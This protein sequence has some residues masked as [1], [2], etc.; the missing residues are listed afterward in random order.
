MAPSSARSS[1]AALGALHRRVLYVAGA[2]AAG[3]LLVLPLLY[4]APGAAGPRGLLPTLIAVYLARKGMQAYRT[5]RRVQQL[6]LEARFLAQ[7]FE[8]GPFRDALT[9]RG[10]LWDSSFTLHGLQCARRQPMPRLLSGEEKKRRVRRCCAR[11][12][13][14]LRPGRLAAF[15]VLPA[16]VLLV[17]LAGAAG[18]LDGGP[19]TLQLG[20]LALPHLLLVEAALL[21][22]RRR[23]RCAHD[24]LLDALTA[25]ALSDDV[26]TAFCERSAYNH[27]LLYHA[28]PHFGAV[29]DVKRNA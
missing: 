8:A 19:L 3:A 15:D 22:L 27:A 1:V 28:H 26:E 6:R 7:P 17:L 9:Q 24:G 4:A 10:H 16:A 13:R 21:A 11:A 29:S 23:L 2:G 20:L 5:Q 25:W 14:T 18:A 12:F